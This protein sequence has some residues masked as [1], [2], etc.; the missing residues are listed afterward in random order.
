M[1]KRETYKTTLSDGCVALIGR[2]PK[3][4]VGALFPDVT[5]TESS[6]SRKH[7][8]WQ[9]NAPLNWN[10]HKVALRFVTAI[11]FERT[12]EHVLPLIIRMLFKPACMN[13][14]VSDYDKPDTISSVTLKL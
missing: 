5:Q 10:L 13:E 1:A 4:P 3:K 9:S 12:I 14:L 6:L 11:R 7:H 2:A 8:R